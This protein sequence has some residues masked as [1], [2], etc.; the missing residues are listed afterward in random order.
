MNAVVHFEIPAENPESLT[1]FFGDVF[2]WSF[3]QFGEE[4]YFLTAANRE[5]GEGIGGA[6]MGRKHPQQPMVNSI[7]VESIDAM[8]PIVESHGGQIVVQK[9]SIPGVGYLAYFKDPENN[10]HGLWQNDSSAT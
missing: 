5:G 2:G 3:Q 9:M 4:K 6:I 8:C 10:I 1:K 7:N